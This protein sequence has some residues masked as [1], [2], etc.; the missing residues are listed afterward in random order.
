MGKKICSLFLC[1]LPHGINGKRVQTKHNIFNKRI[2]K[3]NY[4][5]RLW[6]HLKI[7]PSC[8]APPV[9]P[10]AADETSTKSWNCRRPA[11]QIQTMWWTWKRL[12]WFTVVNNTVCVKMSP[13]LCSQVD[14]G[15]RVVAVQVEVHYHRLW[16]PGIQLSPAQTEPAQE[17]QNQQDGAVDGQEGGRHHGVP[18]A[19]SHHPD[20]TRPHQQSKGQP[21][22][23]GDAPHLKTHDLWRGFII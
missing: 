18:P 15:C 21:V 14:A 4:M 5:T 23:V 1:K 17:A 3:D 6:L 10:S 22:V 16:Q 7:L 11:A 9:S 20:Y 2:M 13:R 8:S 19:V 12:L